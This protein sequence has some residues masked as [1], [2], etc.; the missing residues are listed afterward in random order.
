VVVPT[1]VQGRHFWHMSGCLNIGYQAEQLNL[2]GKVAKRCQFC[3]YGIF[4]ACFKF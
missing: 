2:E 3:H 1:T 4:D